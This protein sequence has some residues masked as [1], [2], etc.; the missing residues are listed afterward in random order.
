VKTRRLCR[1]LA[2]PVLIAAAA[3]AIGANGAAQQP[4][5]RQLIIVVDGLRPDYVTPELMPRLVRLGERGIVFNAHHS[6]VPTV[7]RVNGA[8]LVTGSY[9]ETHGLLGNAIY[10]PAAN[11]TRVLDT[12][13]RE[14]LQAV[15]RGAGHLLTA[16]TLGEL[17]ERTGKRLLAIGTGSTGSAYVLNQAAANR[18]VI[19]PEYVL[20][21]DLAPRVVQRLGPAP[22]AATP[23]TARHRRAV[24]AYLAFG[25]DDARADV[26][27]LW[28]NDPDAAAHGKGI[29]SAVARQSITGVDADIG[30]I[31]DS[32]RTKNLLDRT[33]LIVT[34]DHGFSTHTG[35]FRLDAFVDPFATKLPDGSRDIVVAEGAIH[36]RGQPDQ[37]RVAR[38]VAA[39]QR[40]PEVGA[41]F[42]RPRPGGGAEGVVPGTL[43]FD[44]A[45]WNNAR[46]GEILVSANWTA[47]ANAAGYAGTTTEGGVAGHGSSSPYDIH[48]SLIAAGPDFREHAVSSAPTANVDIAPTLLR[49]LGLPIP[50]SM[51]GRVIEEAL[52]TGPTPWSVRVEQRTESVHTADGSYTLTAHI[53]VAAGHQ[54]LDSTDVVRR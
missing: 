11:Q 27:I 28:L 21:P 2:A 45:R 10:I 23:N 44:V 35:G 46:A 30:R 37:T 54:Y 19:H 7:T 42:T 41:I 29:G 38:V 31:E 43:S 14:D 24:D 25:V 32:L 48:N 6:V 5:H 15:E 50:G 33:N 3:V 26:A 47:A 8:S 16:P 53:S 52:R 39:L 40:R 49:L 9:P 12:G 51:T 20:P 36:F 18:M 34:S 22:P 13:D 1:P 17:L 4:P